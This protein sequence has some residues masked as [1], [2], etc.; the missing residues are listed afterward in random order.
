MAAGPTASGVEANGLN[1]RISERVD[2]IAADAAFGDAIDPSV[3]GAARDDLRIF[4][5][6]ATLNPEPVV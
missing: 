6:S 3:Q 5:M 1:L 2:S 4:V